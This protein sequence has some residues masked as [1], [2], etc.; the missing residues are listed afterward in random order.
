[1][2]NV[3]EDSFRTNELIERAIRRGSNKFDFDRD[4]TYKE[5]YLYSL[6]DYKSLDFYDEVMEKLKGI[7]SKDFFKYVKE[8]DEDYKHLGE[9]YKN[10][11]L[12]ADFT[13][14]AEKLGIDIYDKALIKKYT[15]S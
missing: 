10:R 8:V 1:M 14:F 13:S 4:V 3:S 7:D 5:N 6:E 9:H 12:Q 15:K 11:M 2:L